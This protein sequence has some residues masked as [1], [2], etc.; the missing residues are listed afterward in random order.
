MTNHETCEDFRLS[1]SR[2]QSDTGTTKALWQV[3]KMDD[4]LSSLQTGIPLIGSAADYDRI[5]VGRGTQIAEMS[6]NYQRGAVIPL[7][8][9]RKPSTTEIQILKARL[10]DSLRGF[11]SVIDCDVP[12][13]RDVRNKLRFRTSLDY[14]RKIRNISRTECENILRDLRTH[15]GL[16]STL[17]DSL[18]IFAGPAG[19]ETAT[20]E[21]GT[22]EKIGLHI[23]S[24]SGLALAQRM[25]APSRI[26]INLG[27][28]S[29]DFLFVN[30]P[31][32]EMKAEV[33]N[34]RPPAGLTGIARSFLQTFPRYPL[35][36]ITIHPLEAYLAPTD[37]MIHDA[38]TLRMNNVDFSLVILGA[39][40]VCADL[41]AS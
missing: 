28:Q 12:S 11:V 35:V 33:P 3:G 23:D 8:T 29:R 4:I 34:L 15:S 30:L 27:T 32:S 18:G 6:H 13:V 36:S 14:P 7:Q 2:P 19:Q 26:C 5:R 21:T 1:I 40:E 24:W 16:V 10:L 31:V 37:N 41:V 25:I 17:S 39:F 9:W 22:H 38:S 20:V